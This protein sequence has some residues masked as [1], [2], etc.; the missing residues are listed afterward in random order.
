[1]R[2]FICL[3]LLVAAAALAAADDVAL[4]GVIGDKAA[5]L[6]IGGGEPKTVKVGQTWSG[7]TVVAVT[8]EHATVEIEGKR[9]EL[10]LGQHYRA[11]GQLAATRESVTLAADPRG[12]F[13]ADAAVNGIPMRFVIDTGATAVALSAADASRLGIDWHN[14]ARRTMQTANGATTGYLVKLDKVRVGSIELHDV[15]GVVLEQGMGVGL[16]GMTFLNRVDM[17]RDGDTMTLIRRF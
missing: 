16:L 15:D 5:V 1:M 17:R 13:F 11:G 8:R 9:R 10:T 14:G 4:I 3:S 2:H 6:A 12:H 7:I